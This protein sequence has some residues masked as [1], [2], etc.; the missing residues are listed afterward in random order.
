[1]Q[2]ERVSQRRATRRIWIATA[3]YFAIVYVSQ[4]VLWYL[5]GGSAFLLAI[6]GLTP[7][8]GLAL[9]VRA[10]VRSHRESDELQ[11]R[12]DGEAAVVA[13]LVVGLGSFGYG[14]AAAAVG[15]KTQPTLLVMLVGPLLML[16]WNMAKRLICRR[17]G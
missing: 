12:I 14:L 3:W 15:A 11:R 16:T 2:A 1:M 10:V 8:A 9:M 6:V 13:A 4:W 5:K 7:M 17:Y